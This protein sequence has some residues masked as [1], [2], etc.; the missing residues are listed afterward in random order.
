[1]C[2]SNEFLKNKLLLLP[3]LPPP[4]PPDDDNNNNDTIIKIYNIIVSN[5]QWLISDVMI[6]ISFITV[7]CFP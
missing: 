5:K 2:F 1:M 7:M 4:P 3:P 6:W